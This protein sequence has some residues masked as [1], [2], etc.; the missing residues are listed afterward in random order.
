M[1]HDWMETGRHILPAGALAPMQQHP[2]YGA[3][4]EAIGSGLRRFVLRASN[5]KTIASAQVLERPVPLLGKAALLSR[6]PVWKPKTPAAQQR[7]GLIRLLERLREEHRV[8]VVTPESCADTDPLEGC[9]WMRAMT[10]CQL[11]VLDLSGGPE[12]MRARQHGKGRNRLRRA[13]G[14]GLQVEDSDMPADPA[15]WLLAAE[16]EQARRRHYRRLPPKF[17]LAW[18]AQGG[19][20]SA[21][22]FTASLEGKTVAAM[23]F[24]LHGKAAT[25]H[26]GWSGPEGRAA[27]AHNLLLWRAQ[28]WLANRDVRLLELDL[29]DTQ[30]TPGL[31]RFK[32]GSGARVVPLGATRLSAPGTRFFAERADPAHHSLHMTASLH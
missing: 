27:G 7:D 11:A 25:Y 18:V 24:L 32:L 9:G 6:G 29:V 14:A 15:H 20:H 8:V 21:R 31:A 16:A 22:L 10:P 17:T 3:A 1:T 19:R 28:L 23:L 30:T 12:A 13:Q 5:G 4:C 2:V 26:I